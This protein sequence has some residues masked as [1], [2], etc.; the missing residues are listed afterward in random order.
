[1]YL[2]ILYT[3]VWFGHYVYCIWNMYYILFYYLINYW[4]C[5]MP[6]I[7][8]SIISTL[9]DNSLQNNIENVLIVYLKIDM[10]ISI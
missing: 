5:V 4:M 8:N 3:T 9:I 1:M 10:D 7:D 2:S 6:N